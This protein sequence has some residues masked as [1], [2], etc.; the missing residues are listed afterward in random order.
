MGKGDGACPEVCTPAEF[1]GLIGASERTV[2][3]MCQRG[4][5]DGAEKIAGRWVICRDKALGRAAPVRAQ[6]QR[7]FAGM[8]AGMT[9]RALVALAAGKDGRDA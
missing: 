8:V 7:E 4:R 1:A 3:E 2:R 5:L 9:V 6:D